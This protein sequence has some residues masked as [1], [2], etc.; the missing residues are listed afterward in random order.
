[1]SS[2]MAGAAASIRAAMATI[3]AR[4]IIFLIYSSLFRSRCRA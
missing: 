4:N 3:A 1:L 2:A